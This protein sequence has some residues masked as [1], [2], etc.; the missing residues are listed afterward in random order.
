MAPHK[1]NP[2]GQGGEGRELPDSA[3]LSPDSPNK[4]NTQQKPFL[5]HRSAALALLNNYPELSLKE[6]GFLGH[7]AVTPALS[8]K[9]ESWLGKL[10]TKHK[11]P[12]LEKGQDH[13]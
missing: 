10:L 11:L 6:A 2:A 12:P 8:E 1:P 4:R 5:T 13:G 7:V 3:S 9:Q